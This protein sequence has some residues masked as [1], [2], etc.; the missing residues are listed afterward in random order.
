MAEKKKRI[1]MT[2]PKG[3][4]VFPKLT[5]PD[6]GNAEYPKPDGEYSVNLSMQADDKAT[7]AFLKALQQHYDE[8]IAEAEKEFKGLKVET[9]KKLGEVKTNPL[10]TTVY[11]QE[12]EEPTG[13]IRFKFT[14]K[15]SGTRRADESKWS[16][17]PAI[18]D[19]KG[20][21]MVKVPDIWSGT[22]GKVSFSPS[23]YFIPGTGAAGLKL[24]LNAAQIIDLVANGTRSAT[25]YGFGAEE[26]Y[27][28][29]PNEFDPENDADDEDEDTTT[30]KPQQDI[31]DD[32]P[33]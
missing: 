10:Y 4:F 3:V 7:Q 27:E 2:T 6:Y 1:S 30:S 5:K 22:E 21:P 26:G 16:A 11:D 33:F 12:T 29:E 18:F 13:E 15:A 31:D 20:R 14:M 25:S 28:Y 23:A 19:A 32:I 9:R 8:A 17:K 24:N